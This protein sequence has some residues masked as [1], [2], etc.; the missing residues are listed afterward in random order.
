MSVHTTSNESIGNLL[1]RDIDKPANI[2][3]SK[4]P[5]CLVFTTYFC[6]FPL[7]KQLAH[8]RRRFSIYKKVGRAES[9]ILKSSCTGQ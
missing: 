5:H 6:V 4:V 1:L 9:E 3:K 7:S 8:G 2:T